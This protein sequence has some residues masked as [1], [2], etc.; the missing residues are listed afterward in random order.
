MFEGMLYCGKYNKKHLHICALHWPGEKGPTDEFPDPLKANF[1]KKE[2]EKTSS[3]KR[4]NPLARSRTLP[5][6]VPQKRQKL[7]SDEDSFSSEQDV[8]N[9]PSPE[10]ELEREV[11]QQQ[12]SAIH[13]HCQGNQTEFSKYLLSAKLDTMLL[14]NEVALMRGDPKT[15]PKAVSSISFEAIANN[16]ALMKHF[17]GLTA[18]QFEALHNFHDFICPLDSLTF[19]NCKEPTKAGNGQNAG[20]ESQFS[21]REQLFICIL[22][23]RRGFTIKSNGNIAQFRRQ[24]CQRI[25]N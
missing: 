11:S 9:P 17:V 14:K 6:A 12:T 4:R 10:I 8:M 22:R 16:S 15:T 23:L 20:P 5:G 24:T 21:T 1:T 2:K 18:T 3:R 13:S 7:I 25:H 19:W